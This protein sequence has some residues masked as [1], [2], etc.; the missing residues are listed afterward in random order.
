MFEKLAFTKFTFIIRID[1]E[2]NLPRY[3]GNTLRGGLGY[4][5][6]N[7][8]CIH[9]SNIC[10]ECLIKKS[11]VY[12]YLFDT[13]RPDNSEILRD[14]YEIPKPFII[15]TLYDEKIHYDPGEEISFDLILFGKAIKL[16]P[17]FILAFE[18]IGRIGLGKDKGKFSL[19]RIENESNIIYDNETKTLLSSPKILHISDLIPPDNINSQEISINILTQLRVKYEGKLTDRLEFHILIRNILRRAS[20]LSYFHCGGTMEKFPPE[21]LSSAEKIAIKHNDSRWREWQRY[22]T[23]QKTDMNFGGVVGRIT[24][25]GELEQFI[26]LLLLGE[27]IHVGKNASFGLGK[28]VMN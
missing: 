3:K 20:Y 17:Y 19:E 6:K 12:I 24:Y 22:S 21:I 1:T 16:L 23:R 2:T 10:N 18:N 25:M 11:C 13:I 7:I 9:R 8:T 27:Y 26:P 15:E 5:L 28:Y 14:R 4:S